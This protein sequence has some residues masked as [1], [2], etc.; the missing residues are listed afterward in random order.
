MPVSF[1]TTTYFNP[2]GLAD[3]LQANWEAARTQLFEEPDDELIVDVVELSTSSAELLLVDRRLPLNE[4]SGALAELLVTLNPSLS[5]R[6]DGVVMT[7]DGLL[8]AAWSILQSPEQHLRDAAVLELIRTC[9]VLQIWSGL[10]G[11]GEGPMLESDWQLLAR[12]LRPALQGVQAMGAL[13]SPED[14]A[15]ARAAV[16]LT[17]LDESWTQRLDG[18]LSELVADGRHRALWWERIQIAASEDHVALVLAVLTQEAA[19]LTD[20]SAPSP[21]EARSPLPAG[22]ERV[23]EGLPTELLLAPAVED[24]ELSDTSTFGVVGMLPPDVSAGDPQGTGTTVVTA[25]V[26]PRS[27]AASKGLR[28]KRHRVRNALIAVAVVFVVLGVIGA[29]ASKPK[30]ERAPLAA[31]SAAHLVVVPNPAEASLVVK[32]GGQLWYWQGRFISE[33]SSSAP[34]GSP[35]YARANWLVPAKK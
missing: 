24:E 8:E 9:G 20:A 30:P 22:G 34:A 14:T 19:L 18:S 21:P 5:P 28:R 2:V 33:R 27:E 25:T 6:F 35:L 1:A 13:T 4:A 11:C 16:L 17:L 23:Q 32:R 31:L 10:E 29:L 3:G 15:R 26:R 12:R 7:H